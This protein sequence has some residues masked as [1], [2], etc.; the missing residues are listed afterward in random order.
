MTRTF[1]TVLEGS[2]RFVV[3]SAAV[4]AGMILMVTGLALGVTIVMLP[5]GL[6]VGILG[7]LLFVWGL[8]GHGKANG[9]DVPK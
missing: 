9:H 2:E 8:V 1:R 3:Y 4:V 6:P 5:I 7:V